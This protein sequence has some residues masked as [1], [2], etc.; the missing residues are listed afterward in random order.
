MEI[1][2]QTSNKLKDLADLILKKAKSSGAS[3]AEL[4]IS[5][6]AGKSIAIRL[7]ELETIEVNNDKSLTLSVYFGKRRGLV[8]S[9]DFSLK[10]IEDC[11]YSACE[12][13]KYSQEDEGYGLAEKKY[14]ATEPLDLELYFPFDLKD[15]YLIDYAIETEAEALN[16]DKLIKNSEGVQF[17]HSETNFIY[18][19]SNGFIGGFPS[20][21]VSLSCSVIASDKNQMQNPY[22]L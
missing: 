14:L 1:T 9:S 15:K 17:S 11:V 19:N 3:D 18:A 10:A 4:E 16:F 2:D 6:T 7:S 13:A 12:I 8:T 20:S 22:S 5:N 21:R